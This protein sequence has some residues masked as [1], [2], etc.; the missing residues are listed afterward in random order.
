M[1]ALQVAL[2]SA[3]GMSLRCKEESTDGALSHSRAGV[4]AV[5]QQG[6]RCDDPGTRTN[7]YLGG[8]GTLQYSCVCVTRT[9]V[10]DKFFF[11]ITNVMGTFFRMS[12]VHHL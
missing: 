10:S 3:D 6:A 5:P 9:A 4:R 8:G 12:E 1:A 2:P 7:T 11:F